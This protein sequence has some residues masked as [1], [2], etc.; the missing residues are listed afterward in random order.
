MTVQSQAEEVL[1]LVGE[2][3]TAS[4]GFK[5][6][7]PSETTRIATLEAAKKLVAT[8]DKPEDTIYKHAYLPTQT[9]ASRV[10]IDLDIFNILMKADGPMTAKDLAEVTD[11][12][13]VLIV[14]VMRIL[15]LINFVT[16]T[17]PQTYAPSALTKTLTDKFIRGMLKSI[18]DIGTL[19]LASSPQYL[20]NIKHQNHLTQSKGPFEFANRTD[21]N[22][23]GWLGTHPEAF[24]D[25]NTFM[26]GNRGSRPAWVHWYPVEKQILEGFDSKEDAVLFVDVAGGRGHDLEVFRSKFPQAP[27]RLVLEDL[28]S[29]IDDSKGLNERIEKVKHDFFTPQPIKGARVYYMK[30]V[31]HDWEDGKCGEILKHITAAMTKGY[32]KLIVEDFILPD[33]GCPLLPAMWDIEMMAFCNALERSRQQW[34]DLM[35]SCGL[36]VKGFWP[37]P[38]DGQGIIEAMLK[39]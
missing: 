4:Q 17:G 38:G 22:L 12:D 15:A 34:L 6:S 8:L 9:F 31:L 11:A 3:D 24:D 35:E 26:E 23:F 29:V 7:A 33:V 21:Y 1:R 19:V 14:R 20:R 30:F 2:I 37:P 13:H 5:D 25:F 16:E 32:S 27:G 10:A 28:P 18:Y 36:E 39:E